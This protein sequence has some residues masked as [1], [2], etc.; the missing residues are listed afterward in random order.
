[1]S[2]MSTTSKRLLEAV[3]TLPEPLQAEVLDFADFLR[4]RHTRSTSLPAEITLA[5]LCGGL[6]NT[7]TF[8]ESPQAIQQK[9]RNEWR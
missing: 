1:M 7:K 5:S 9:L 2:M 4:A 6:E 3:Q 8:N